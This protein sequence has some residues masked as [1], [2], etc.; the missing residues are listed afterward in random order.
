MNKSKTK[1]KHQYLEWATIQTLFG[2]NNLQK[3]QHLHH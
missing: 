2:Q 1:I 3:L